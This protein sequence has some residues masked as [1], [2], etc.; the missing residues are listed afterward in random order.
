LLLRCVFQ[1]NDRTLREDEIT[2][3]SASVVAA[4]TSLGGTLRDGH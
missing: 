3:W 2:A 4:L 1:S